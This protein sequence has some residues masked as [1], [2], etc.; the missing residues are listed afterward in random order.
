VGD[1]EGAGLAGG[2]VVGQTSSTQASASFVDIAFTSLTTN[3][4][5]DVLYDVPRRADDSGYQRVVF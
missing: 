5:V 4:P 2:V 1:D 3:I